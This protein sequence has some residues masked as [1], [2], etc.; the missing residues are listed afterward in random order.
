MTHAEMIAQ[1]ERIAL[2]AC[3]KKD[4]NAQAEARRLAGLRSFA[5][6]DKESLSELIRR[7][8]K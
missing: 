1:A 6:R 7:F 2:A 8:G 5:R 4:R 3:A